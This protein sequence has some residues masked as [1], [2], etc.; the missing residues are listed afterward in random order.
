V[1]GFDHASLQTRA[2]HAE[3]AR[4][5]GISPA[6]LLRRDLVYEFSGA[7]SAT[8]ARALAAVVIVLS[9]LSFLG[10]GA[11]PPHRDLGLMIAAA[12]AYYIHAW[13]TAAF[14]ALALL[15]LVL[16]AR[17]AAGLDEGERP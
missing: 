13:W 15:I 10:F 5:S 4:A 9:T 12:K 17:L 1:R 8:A 14:P 11:E 7:F 16:F 3:Y 2:A 6:T